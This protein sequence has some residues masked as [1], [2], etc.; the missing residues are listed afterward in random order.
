MPKHASSPDPGQQIAVL[1]RI[2]RGAVVVGDRIL[3]DAAAAE[4]LDH[5]IDAANMIRTSS[6]TPESPRDRREVDRG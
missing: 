4:L 1:I 3:R 2:Y 5:G 6:P